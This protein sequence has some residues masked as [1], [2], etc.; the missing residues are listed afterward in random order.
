MPTSNPQGDE[1]EVVV[2]PAV[3]ARRD[4]AGEAVVQKL[5][6]LAG[7]RRAVD[8][9]E[10]RR[11]VVAQSL[12]PTCHERPRVALVERPE[13]RLALE[14]GLELDDVLLPH[15]LER[16]ESLR[17]E[18]RRGGE[19][20]CGDDAVRE[21]RGAG[22]RMR[23]AAGDAPGREPVEAEGVGDHRDVVRGVGD[24]AAGVARGAA[25]AGA[26]VGDEADPTP[27]G[28]LVVRRV[29]D[30][31]ARRSVVGDHGEPVGIAA[32]HDTQ[33]ASAAGVDQVLG[34]SAGFSGVPGRPS[35]KSSLKRR[36]TGSGTS[37][38]TSPP[39]AA[40]SFTP[41]EETKLTCGLAIT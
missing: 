21:Q 35:G 5:R 37:P 38:E 6:E 9:G 34:H 41:L 26:V 11:D 36:A 13:R 15:A 25:V 7:E 40:I 27:R 14:H 28:V 4:G 32:L 20:G 18:R 8:R 33:D 29:G 12:G 2:D 23:A 30:G 39:N 22:E 16:V 31:A 19:T 3:D 1:G 10:E 24:R 17:V